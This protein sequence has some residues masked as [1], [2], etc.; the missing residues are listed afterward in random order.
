MVGTR[1]KRRASTE[2]MIGIAGM[3]KALSDA[4]AN[5]DKT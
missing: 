3:A 1:R 5:K 2:N 4:V